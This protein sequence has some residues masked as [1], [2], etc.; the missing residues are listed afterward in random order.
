MFVQSMRGGEHGVLGESSLQM[1]LARAIVAREKPALADPT[2]DADTGLKGCLLKPDKSDAYYA[3]PV[4]EHLKARAEALVTV[5]AA[6]AEAGN[7]AAPMA[8]DQASS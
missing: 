4:F 5:D 6:E 7:L 3:A 8:V 2:N 1:Q